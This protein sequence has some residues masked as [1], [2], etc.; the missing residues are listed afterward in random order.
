MNALNTVDVNN[1]DQ[2]FRLPPVRFDSPPLDVRTLSQQVD[3]GLRDRKM[4]ELWKRSAG[5][6]VL[7]IILDTGVAVHEDLPEPLFT[8]NFTDNQSP[9]DQNSHQTHCAG[10]VAAIDN[11]LGV[12]GWAPKATLAHIKVLSD[13]GSGLS[14]WITRG[15]QT[16]TQEWI[17]RKSDFIGCIVS[18]S[19]GG[20]FDRGQEQAIVQANE[21]GMIVVAAAGNRG[22][23]S[24]GH[25][26]VDHPGASK[27]TIGVAAYRVDGN[28]A[29]FS[30]GGPE[31]DIAMPGEKILSTI[32]GNQY[33][34]MSGTSMATP[35]AAG[36]IACILSSR[37]HDQSLRTIVGLRIFLQEHCEDRGQPGRDVR[38][39]VGVPNADR[40]ILDPEYWFF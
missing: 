38:F 27:F 3:W 1:P 2:L 15:L 14:T 7:V 39:G 21:A 18:M 33:Q 5:E 25:S 17:K 23:R 9:Y 24:D 12:V 8:Y 13:S 32:P 4:P 26:T 31:V 22:F 10:I 40:A 28:I 16:A 35:A 20:S 30:S 34:I 6:G 19:L 29:S 37:P 36:L 11:E